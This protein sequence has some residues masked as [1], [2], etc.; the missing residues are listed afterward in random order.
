[1]SVFGVFLVSIFPHLNWTRR[2]TEYLSVFSSNAEKY[3]PGKI[4]IRTLFIQCWLLALGVNL[5]NLKCFCSNRANA[6]GRLFWFNL[7]LRLPVIFRLNYIMR[8]DEKTSWVR[9]YC[10]FISGPKLVLVQS[11]NLYE[12]KKWKP[13]TLSRY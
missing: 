4:G 5:S 13:I 2:E 10:L 6:L 3:G 8:R 7:V 1:M 9:S 11:K 12:E